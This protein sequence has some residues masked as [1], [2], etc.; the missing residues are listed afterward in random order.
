MPHAFSAR[1]LL[2]SAIAS[3]LACA[4]DP[5]A[6]AHDAAVQTSGRD[7]SAS[8][9]TASKDASLTP[10]SDAS[11]TPRDTRD[12]AV[13]RPV[14]AS[15]RDAS[16]RSD[17]AAGAASCGGKSLLFCEDFEAQSEGEATATDAW[18]PVA[19][20]G[21][22]NIESGPSRPGRA[23]HLHTEGNGRAYLALSQF[24]APE[25]GFFGRM[26]VYVEQ[27]PSAPAY[28]HYT[29]VEAAGTGAGMIRP[30]GGQY[31]PG[32]GN[33]LGPGS[34]GGPTGDWTHW[35]PSAPLAEKKW[36]CLEWQLDPRD[37]AIEVWIDGEHK[38]DLSV[39][40]KQHGGKAV[41]FVFP[42]FDQL[43]FGWWLYQANPTP[44]AYDVWLDDLALDRARIGC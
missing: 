17:G 10:S 19:S 20:N 13:V 21:A 39:S 30:I 41:D 1:A 22:L 24:S 4:S 11:Q 5:S 37:N 9:P 3:P 36:V 43:W 44:D 27:L 16:T 25:D 40:T 38:P 2:L 35:K 6:P 7:S 23:L 34:D 26:R 32:Q 33:L 42:R 8:T 31:I 18:Q 14:D 15:A 29:L 28:A 12:A